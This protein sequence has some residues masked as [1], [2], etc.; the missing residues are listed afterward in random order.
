[1]DILIIL[2]LVASPLLAYLTFRYWKEAVLLV[3]VL[4]VY[5]GALR[6]WVFPEQ[7]AILY[8]L[9]DGLLMAAFVG[10]LFRR[11]PT[12]AHH[13]L[14]S[15]LLVITTLTMVYCFLQIAN[16][17]SP[18][19]L[20]WLNGF[21]AYFLYVALLFMVPYVFRS[22]S[23]LERKLHYYVMM[24]IPVAVLGLVQF[25]LP[26]D[27][28]INQQ[29]SHDIER[30]IVA[31]SFGEDLRAR[32]SGTFSYIGGYA[33]F[34]ACMFALSI[35]YL[36]SGA[37]TSRGYWLPLTLLG[38]TSMGLFTT[39]SRTVIL[40]ALVTV[41]I[42][43]LLCAKE[44]MLAGRHVVRMYAGA[45]LSVLLVAAFGLDA[46]EA[47]LFRS[48]NADS[49]E[50]RILTPI[51]EMLGAFET[52]PIFGTGLGT[53]HNSASWVM[54]SPEPWWLGPHRFEVETARVMQE[55]GL[56]GFILVY[57]PRIALIFVAINMMAR[58]QLRLFK[59]LCAAIAAYFFMQL[60][61][62]VINNPTGGLYFW[63]A[64]GLLYAMYKLES[65]ARSMQS[66]THPVHPVGQVDHSR[67]RPRI[68]GGSVR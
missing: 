61:L 6:K 57:I 46:V 34:L 28:I 26:P 66:Y 7:Q 48:M 40:S 62:F 16:P 56:I 8:L 14:L 50:M 44:R 53:S 58:L 37:R 22:I 60:G 30:E 42:V 17:N 25:A 10:F 3:M 36:A 52:Q 43:V 68:H 24:M 19:P 67:N 2:M 5:E 18:S 35:A 39:G 63:F 12:G 38:T 45:A 15:G 51:T 13:R 33:T 31:S 64:A 29:L 47:M 55:L 27:H 49:A 21:K 20:I 23:D 32:T 4:M 9:K 65:E 54:N 11:E 41:V 59:A 1:L